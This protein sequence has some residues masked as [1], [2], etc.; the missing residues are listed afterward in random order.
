MKAW[1]LAL[2]RLTYNKNYDVVYT[3]LTQSDLKNFGIGT[4]D[5]EGLSNFLNT[6]KDAKIIMVL[7][8]LSDGRI[9]GSLRTTRHD[10]DVSKIAMCLGGGGHKKAAGFEI[11]G[12]LRQTDA[13]W[14]VF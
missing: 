2:S 7:Y 3:V 10:V 5:L 9:K 6:L 13:G 4:D 12:Q 11:K 8:E 1:G 14:E